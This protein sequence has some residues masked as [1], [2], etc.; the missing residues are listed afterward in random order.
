[1]S[2]LPCGLP[3]YLVESQWVYQGSKCLP[4]ETASLMLAQVSGHEKMTGSALVC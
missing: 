4:M 3:A 1:M 2:N